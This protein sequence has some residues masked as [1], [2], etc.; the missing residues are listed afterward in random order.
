T[1]LLFEELRAQF[2]ALAGAF[3][4]LFPVTLNS[5]YCYCLAVIGTDIP[6]E[7]AASA[8]HRLSTLNSEYQE[9]VRSGRLGSVMVRQ[10][11]INQLAKLMGQDRRWESQFKL[12]PLYERPV[13]Q[14][15]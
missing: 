14:P 7:L 4:S 15:F 8:E 5:P 3:L 11:D 10:L 1:R 2:P 9:K 12:M 6:I 13:V